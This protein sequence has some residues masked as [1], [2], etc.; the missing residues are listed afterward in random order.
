M[1]KTIPI[2]I[3]SAKYAFD[4]YRTRVQSTNAA[5]SKL[6]TQINHQMNV[7]MENLLSRNDL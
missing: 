2:S 6:I 7:E 3:M 4:Y 1:E 5:D